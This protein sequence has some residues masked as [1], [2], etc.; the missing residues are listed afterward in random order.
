MMDSYK[1]LDEQDLYS[2]LL[3]HQ[4]NLAHLEQIAAKYGSV[5]IPLVIHNQIRDENEK[6]DGINAELSSRVKSSSTPEVL[7]LPALDVRVTV[8]A[9]FT[10]SIYGKLIFLLAISV[11]NHSPVA[12]CLRGGIFIETRSN[13]IVVPNG[14]FLTNEYQRLREIQPGQSFTL[15]IDPEEIRTHKSLGLVCAATRDDLGRVYRSDE[16]EF[17]VALQIL[18]EQYVPNNNQH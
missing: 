17:A 18:F 13:G 7:T 1:H 16:A 15:N 10:T 9:G 6:I 3:Q 5:G 12:V 4:R 11:Q 8:N 14:D 2:L